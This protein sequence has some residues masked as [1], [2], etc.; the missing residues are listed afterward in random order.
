MRQK[1]GHI[2]LNRDGQ[3]WMAGGFRSSW[4]KACSKTCVVGVTFN[5]LREAAVSRLALVGCTEPEIAQLAGILCD[6]CARYSIHI[7]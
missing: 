2:L 4:R 5:D 7:T 6:R 3:P 1:A